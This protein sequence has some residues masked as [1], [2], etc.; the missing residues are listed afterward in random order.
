MATDTELKYFPKLVLYLI[1]KV[2]A[3]KLIENLYL[4]YMSLWNYAVVGFSGYLI[5]TTVLYSLVNMAPLWLA[6]AIAVIIAFLCNW[7]F[8]VGPLGFYMGLN[9]K[10]EKK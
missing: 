4:K 5:N 7:M 3:P 9:K 6:N 1:H 8:S 10:E 2:N